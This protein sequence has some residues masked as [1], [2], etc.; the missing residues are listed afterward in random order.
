MR[1]PSLSIPFQ[2]SINPHAEYAELHG[3]RFVRRF[4]LLT[5]AEAERHFDES[6]LGILVARACPQ[7]DRE[8]IAIVADWMACNLVLDDLF[9]ETEIGKDPVLLREFCDRV[10][11]WLAE[12]GP[13]AEHDGSP[14]ARAYTDLWTRTCARAS[15]VW[16]RR[17]HEHF[18]LFLNRCV[19]E[20]GNRKNEVTPDVDEYLRMRACAFMP[21]IDLLELVAR[22]EVPDHLYRT[23]TFGELNQ[24]LSDCVL[25]TNDLYSCEKEYALGDVHNLVVV[26]AAAESIGLQRAAEIVGD[27]IGER[28]DRFAQISEE[29]R[30]VW[31]PECADPAVGTALAGHIDN[32]RYWLSGQMQWRFETK[33]NTSTNLSLVNGKASRVY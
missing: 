18:A 10:L 19:W 9:D 25:W 3:R 29:I 1:F 23:D 22:W 32:M 8:T 12:D 7:A 6:L 26:L 2:A 21:Y 28:I 13:V 33:R 14:F 27:M 17:F 30:E 16:R 24:A 5:T 11:V 15:P 31:A 20:S 4:D